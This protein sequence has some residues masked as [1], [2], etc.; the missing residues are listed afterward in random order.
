MEE[1]CNVIAETMKTECMTIMARNSMIVNI[2]S[3]ERECEQALT[4]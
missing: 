2:C 3:R 1:S 4:F